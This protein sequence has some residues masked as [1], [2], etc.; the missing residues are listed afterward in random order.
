MRGRARH[1]TGVASEAKNEE[2]RGAT[3]IGAKASRYGAEE[4]GHGIPA[5]DRGVEGCRL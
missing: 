3:G 2:S 5:N 4:V 1:E